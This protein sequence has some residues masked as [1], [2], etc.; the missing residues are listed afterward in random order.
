MGDDGSGAGWNEY[1]PIAAE[2]CRAWSAHY[3]AKGANDSKA[4]IL[5]RKKFKT[6]PPGHAKHKPA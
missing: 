4:W 3:R 6:W 5:A 1:D 2:R